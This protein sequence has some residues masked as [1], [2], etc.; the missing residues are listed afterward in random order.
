MR[1]AFGA[2]LTWIRDAGIVQLFAEISRI[3]RGTFATERLVNGQTFPIILTWRM[4]TSVFA[5]IVNAFSFQNPVLL[6]NVQF[7]FLSANLQ[8]FYTTL[9]AFVSADV[10][11]YSASKG[12]PLNKYLEYTLTINWS[13]WRKYLEE[14]FSWTLEHNR[15]GAI[16]YGLRE[17]NMIFVQIAQKNH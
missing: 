16:G 1:F 11:V 6:V 15:P 5:T 13:R 2:V 17:R 8:F 7:N 9:E 12:R 3:K 14:F 10:F 4:R